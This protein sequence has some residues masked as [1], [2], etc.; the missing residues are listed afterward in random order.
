MTV[1][2]GPDIRVGHAE[3]DQ[4]V[5]VL[6]E[7]AAEGRLM[8]QELDGRIEEALR[9]KTRGDLHGVLADLVPRGPLDQMLDAGAHVPSLGPGYSWEDPLV[10]VARWEDERRLG[11]WEV[12]PF[13]E[14]NPVA[15]NVKLNFSDARPVSLVIDIVLRGGAGDCVLVVPGGWGV[16]TE[17]VTKGLGG[18]R[19]TVEQ[20]PQRGSPQ[21]V[22]RGKTSLGTLKVRHPNRYDIWQLE[23]HRAKTHPP[24]G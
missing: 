24:P 19:S 21:I 10:V 6:R 18:I 23:R 3:R 15:A 14:A 8:L 11:A 5:D 9:A 4:A 7:A 16:D 2:E 1:P 20:R 17:Q 13:I 12:P 22:V